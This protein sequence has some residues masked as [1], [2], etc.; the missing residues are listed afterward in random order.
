MKAIGIDPA[1]GKNSTVCYIDE[2]EK[3]IIRDLTH[4]C[5]QSFLANLEKEVII[6]W[7]APLTSGSKNATPDFKKGVFTK[8]K[9]EKFFTK[10]EYEFQ[11]PKGISIR[12]YCGCPH[13]TITKFMLGYPIIGGYDNANNQD[14]EL[15]HSQ[16]D[17]IAEKSY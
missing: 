5:L 15:I 7:D 10:K 14:F 1:P 9:I 16:K 17:L 4:S 8:R 13:W 2:N 3:I 6:S 12:G 11:T